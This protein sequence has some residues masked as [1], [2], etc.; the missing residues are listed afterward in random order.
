MNKETF[1][2]YMEI[3][4]ESLPTTKPESRISALYRFYGQQP[5]QLIEETCNYIAKNNER[6]PTPAAFSVAVGLVKPRMPKELFYTTKKE[7]EICKGEGRFSIF[8]K[9]DD[10]SYC[11]ACN[12][13]NAVGYKNHPV[14]HKSLESD[15]YFDANIYKKLLENPEIF[16]KGL[17]VIGARMPEEVRQNIKARIIEYSS[18]NKA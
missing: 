3:V 8:K 4:A 16:R 1:F 9:D 13:S 10:L 15:Y 11:F 2:E 18:K 6:F 7:C 5:E 17:E 12:C 14:W